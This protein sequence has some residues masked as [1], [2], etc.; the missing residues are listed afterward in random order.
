VFDLASAK[1]QVFKIDRPRLH[2][3][4]ALCKELGPVVSCSVDILDGVSQLRI[5]LIVTDDS[6][7]VTAN[8]GDRDRAWCC[9][10]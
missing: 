5:P 3:L 8:S 1:A 4:L 6:G 9:A 10:V 2:H 7:I